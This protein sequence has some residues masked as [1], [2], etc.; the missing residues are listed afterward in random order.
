MRRS[1]RVAGATEGM[2]YPPLRRGRQSLKD[3]MRASIAA[4]RMYAAGMDEGPRKDEAM[5]RL[6]NQAAAIPPKRN[7]VVRPVDHK[8]AFPL[9]RNI[10]KA[11]LQLLH[12]HP[13]VA[14]AYRINSGTFT[15][16]NRD[17]SQRYI[18]AHTMRGMSDV[19]AVLR[20]GR[21]CFFEIKR[22]GQRAN[23]LQQAFIDR[24]NAAGAIAAVVTD[25]QE[26]VDLLK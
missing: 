26:I 5:A 20:G 19:C 8:P 4:Q 21:A 22:P 25:P 14:F 9:E 13:K 18:S 24:A 10:Q 16:Q 23:P 3:S 7:R 11:C 15:E 2:S 17:G 6:D 1:P 12:Q